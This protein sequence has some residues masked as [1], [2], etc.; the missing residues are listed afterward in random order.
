MSI[1]AIKALHI[2]FVVSWF[3]GLFYIV[4]LFIYH[5]EAQTKPDI[6]KNILSE[7]FKIME[8][9]LWYIITFPAMIL[10]VVFGVWLFIKQPYL[11]KTGWMHVKLSL[12]VCLIVYH[13]ICHKIFLN[14]Q[15]NKIGWTSNQLRLWN[16]L[17]TLFLVAI[18]FVVMQK[19]ATNWVLATL[20]FFGIAIGLMVAIKLYK[21]FRKA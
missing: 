9:K 20:L 10:T 6:E 3:A 19:N 5:S 12:L 15:K 18:V 7:Q 2:I 17:A 14:Y 13:F 4:R 21:K 11:L 16:E 1:A 8:R